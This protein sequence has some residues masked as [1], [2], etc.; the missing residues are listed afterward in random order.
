MTITTKRIGT[1]PELEK[2]TQLSHTTAKTNNELKNDLTNVRANQN[3][4][5]LFSTPDKLFEDL[6]I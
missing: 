4:S 2:P 3:L 1:T 5:R 6:K